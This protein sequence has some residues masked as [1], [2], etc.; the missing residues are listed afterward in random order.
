MVNESGLSTAGRA[1][2]KHGF[3]YCAIGP[4]VRMLRC[5]DP[6]LHHPA[7]KEHESMPWYY[8]PEEVEFSMGGEKKERQH[9]EC[10]R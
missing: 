7:P 9:A 5:R 10:G 1:R 6:W 8:Y 2:G 4:A 3:P